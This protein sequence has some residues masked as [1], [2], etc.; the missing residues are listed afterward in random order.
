MAGDGSK[1]KDTNGK[2]SEEY[3]VPDLVFVETNDDMK[4]EAIKFIN[5]AL[6]EVFHNSILALFSTSS[7]TFQDFPS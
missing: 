2:L 1:S 3:D 5:N 4:D 6:N 7:V